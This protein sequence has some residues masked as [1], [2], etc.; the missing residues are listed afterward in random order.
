MARDMALEADIEEMMAVGMRYDRMI[1]L[2]IVRHM[3]RYGDAHS[4]LEGHTG[5]SER[6]IQR[7]MQRIR[8][9]W[10]E[11]SEKTRPERRAELERKLDA[12]FLKAYLEGG[13]S[14]G[15]AVRCLTQMAKMHGLDAAQKIEI[16]GQLD[17]KA[18]S[19]IER[20]ARISELW[21]L[22]QRSLGV[23]DVKALPPKPKKKTKAA[24][25]KPKKA[26]VK[27]RKTVK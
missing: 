22:R 11:E 8:K 12:T 14:L 21:E 15:S 6:T 19:P 20:R 1:P 9:R 23:V 13:A 26:P 10:A 4:T 5:C 3:E 16:T 7:Y 18:M 25:R 17:I 27:G 24:K 2:I